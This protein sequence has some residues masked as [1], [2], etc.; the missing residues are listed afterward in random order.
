MIRVPAFLVLGFWLVLQFFS[1][2]GSINMDGGTAYFAHIGGFLAGM[3]LIPFFKNKDVKLFHEQNTSSWQ[4][5]N[6][7]A[8]EFSFQKNDST[9]ID[10]IKKSEEEMKRRK[11]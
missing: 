4:V 6:R 11:H 10:F 8:K 5:F 9:V 2:P 7:G 1:I 3:I